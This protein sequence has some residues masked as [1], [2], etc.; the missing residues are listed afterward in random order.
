MTYLRQRNYDLEE[1][2]RQKAI[3]DAKNFLREGDS[4]EKISRCIGLPL[5]TVL[6]LQKEITV[7]A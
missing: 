4:P 5:E 3:E 1:G 2:R 7:N 6:K